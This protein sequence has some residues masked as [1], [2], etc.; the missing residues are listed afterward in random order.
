VSWKRVHRVVRLIWVTAGLSFVGWMLWS[1]QAHQVDA[2]AMRSTA[3]V[4]VVEGDDAMAFLPAVIAEDR[5]A[6]VFLPGGMVDPD[7]YVP[8][9]RALAEAGWPSA[10]V[11]L[12]WR[13]AFTD[14]STTEVW[15]RVQAVRNVL[16]RG[17][18]IVI[19]GHS[20]G[21]AMS[22]RFTSL[23]PDEIAGLFMLGTTHPRDENLSSFARPVLKVSG[24]LDCVADLE[25]TLKNKR[26]LPPH[27]RWVTIEGANHAQ[28]GYYGRQLGD[29]AAAIDRDAQ[30]RQTHEALVS[31]L[32][33]VAIR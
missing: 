8:V 11:E 30:Q 1:V 4:T 29:C 13:M 19:G 25:E 33:T 24:S 16:G 9:V 17:R 7:A 20:R 21:A 2:A 32:G 15:R 5:P 28:F 14:D 3:D 18:P 31:W 22:A 23:H 27:T 12:P 10:I 26:R 6:I